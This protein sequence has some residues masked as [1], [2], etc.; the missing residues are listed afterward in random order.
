MAQEYYYGQMNREEQEAYRGMFAGFCEIASEISVRRL[1]NRQLSDVF[2]RLRL[3]H[4]EIFYVESFQYRFTEDSQYVRMKPSYMFEKKK[5]KEHQKALEGRINRLTRQ[6]QGKTKEEA[7]QFIHDFI[8][9][10]VTYDK[11]KKQYS[12]EIIGP[13]QHGVGVC[14][15]IAKT[16]KIL[17]DRLNIECII[18]VSEAAPDQG[19]K[20]R[21]AWNVVKPGKTWYHLDATFDNSLGRYGAARFDYFN[22]GD[23]ELFRDHQKLLYPV[24]ACPDSGSFYYREQR[25]SLTKEEDV[26]RRLKT[27]LRKKQPYFVF[28]WRGGKLNRELVRFFYEEACRTAEEKGKFA[29]LSVNVPQSVIEIA[30]RDRQAEKE[31]QEEEANEEELTEQ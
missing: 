18:A 25:L 4:P 31:I 26:A 14:E 5:I 6:A 24:P 19:I 15:G 8:C 17:C 1:D 13:L 21:H 12:H 16:V 2:F 10:N 29:A 27:A 7:E 22:L 30:I 9:E 20:Y 11:L 23:R 3:D 28:H